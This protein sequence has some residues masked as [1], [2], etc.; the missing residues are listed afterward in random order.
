MKR[1]GA[2][3]SVISGLLLF[4]AHVSNLGAGHAGTVLG[5]TLVLCA[6]LL[7]VFA[8]FWLYVEQGDNNGILGNLGMTTGI[9]GTVLVTAIVYVEIA[10]VAGTQVDAVF[11]VSVPKFI[12]VFAPLLFVLGMILIGIS[13]IRGKVLLRSGGILLIAG[14]LI[15]AA[16]SFAG[17]AE[18]IISVIGSAVTGGGFIWL[19]LSRFKESPQ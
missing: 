14:T 10:G 13:I 3:S 7:I 2:M 17:A 19:G 5:K 16:G 6:H 9:I 1:L 18:A 4:L 8:F 12:H 11:A 15:F